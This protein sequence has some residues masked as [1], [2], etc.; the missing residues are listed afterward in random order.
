MYHCKEIGVKPDILDFGNSEWNLGENIVLKELEKEETPC[1]GTPSEYLAFYNDD[2]TAIK[3]HETCLALGGTM[4]VPKNE[5]EFLKLQEAI[6]ENGKKNPKCSQEAGIY[7]PVYQDEHDQTKWI[8]I[9]RNQIMSIPWQNGQPNG[10]RFQKC[11]EA[12]YGFIWD[13]ECDKTANCYYCSMKKNVRFSLKGICRSDA[14]NSQGG[15]V[16]EDFTL[17]PGEDEKPSWRGFYKTEISWNTAEE[18]WQITRIGTKKIV[19]LYNDTKEFPIGRRDWI[20]LDNNCAQLSKEKKL[21]LMLSKCSKDE[22]PCSEGN[23]IPLTKKCDFARE[24][25]D[26]YDEIHCKTLDEEFIGEKYDSTLPN[27]VADDDGHY[28]ATTVNI[29]AKEKLDKPD[30]IALLCIGLLRIIT[31]RNMSFDHNDS[32]N[33]TITKE[34]ILCFWKP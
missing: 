4:P 20:F 22:F 11:L 30:K 16:D 25:S 28:T 34:I 31:R 13:V 19:A 9:Q 33:T 3:G 12:S 17:K 6:V 23:C 8:D 1:G 32:T 29:S 14:I 7:I 24:C 27:I 26:G 18:F 2:K 5:K 10:E 21:S 15:D